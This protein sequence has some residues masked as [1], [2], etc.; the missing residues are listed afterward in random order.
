MGKIHFV[1]ILTSFLIIGCS[2]T[3]TASKS[4][5]ETV[6]DNSKQTAEFDKITGISLIRFDLLKN[7]TPHE[8]EKALGTP[9]TNITTIALIEKKLQD[10]ESWLINKQYFIAGQRKSVFFKNN[11]VSGWSE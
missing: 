6:I 1:F 9:A 10:K 3:D 8:V 5:K 11:L 2:H 7:M 4:T